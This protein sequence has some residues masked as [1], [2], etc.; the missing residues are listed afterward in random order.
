AKQHFLNAMNT[1]KRIT[2]ILSDRSTEQLES[3]DITTSSAPQRNYN[4]DLE[5]IKKFIAT[6]KSIA[7][8]QSVSFDEADRLITQAEKQIKENDDIGLEAT[9]KQLNTILQDIQK[10]L[11]KHT[12]QTAFDRTITFFSDM[13]DRLEKR[14]ADETLL[15]DAKQMLSD[16]ELL[17]A[18]GNYDEAEQLKDELTQKI[19]ELYSSIK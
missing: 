2:S 1:F 15:N 17:V 6:L 10:E 8:S 7:R 9:L 16:F 11:R 13:L 5:R 3:A 4:N 14:G 19:R 18:D 12:S